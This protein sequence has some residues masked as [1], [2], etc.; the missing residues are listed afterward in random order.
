[1]MTA[2]G[3]PRMSTPEISV[4][5]E[6]DLE[7]I[8]QGYS[9]PAWWYDLRGIF[10]L[11][12]C[13]QDTVWSLA[14]FFARNYSSAH[15]EAA[16][17]T[18]T[19]TRICLAWRRLFVRHAEVPGGAMFDYSP[20]MLEGAKRKFGNNPRWSVSIADVGT[21]P[22][23]DASFKTVNVTNALHSFPDPEVALRELHRVMLK[24]GTLAMNVLYWPTDS[25]WA[26]RVSRRM[27]HW[28]IGTGML[29]SPYAPEYIRELAQRVGFAIRQEFRY[30]YD[31]YWVLEKL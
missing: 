24:Q 8:R 1:M 15:L 31:S 6:A 11:T 16:V 26:A 19:L 2:E 25:T 27:M 10:I 20:M 4:T 13:H 29:F 14:R 30:G 7:K 21:L 3:D 17:G 28:G 18:G 12:L 5:R 9:S 22:F 23:P